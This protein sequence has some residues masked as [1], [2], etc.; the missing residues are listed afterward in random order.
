MLAYEFDGIVEAD[1]LAS[2]VGLNVLLG[3]VARLVIK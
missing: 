1:D 2:G 3:D